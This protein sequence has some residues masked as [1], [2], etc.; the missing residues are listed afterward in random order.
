M[1]AALANVYETTKRHEEAI[2]VYERIPAGTPLE[3]SVEIRKAINLNLLERTDE[4]KA[5]LDRLL[6]KSLMICGC[7][8]P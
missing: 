6:E 1:L 8:T 4:A 5:L 3:T 7:W 2:A